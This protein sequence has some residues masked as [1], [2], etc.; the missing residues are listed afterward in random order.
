MI[1]G[2]TGKWGEWRGR[3]DGQSWKST[4][5]E[6]GGQKFWPLAAFPHLKWL[7]NAMTARTLSAEGSCHRLKLGLATGH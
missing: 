1:G 2:G 4:V 5:V 3:A 6:V 7:T